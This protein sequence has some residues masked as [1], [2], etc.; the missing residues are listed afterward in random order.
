MQ[1]NVS[2]DLEAARLEALQSYEVLDSK[3]ERAFDDL[4]SLIADVCQ[5]P[6]ALVSLIDSGRQ[7]F[8]S[9]HGLDAIE[10]P[11]D[12][13]FCDHA[14]RKQ[15]VMVVGDAQQD[16]RFANNPLVTGAPNIRFY[17]GSPLVDTDGHALGTLCVIDREPRHLTSKQLETL[18]H[19]S[20]QVAHL[21]EMRRNHRKLAGCL[22]R[23]RSIADMIPMCGHC[24]AVRDESDEWQRV[25]QYFQ[26]VSGTQFTHG[27]CPVCMIEHYPVLNGIAQR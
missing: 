18:E 12:Q 7:W 20:R 27:V 25:E 10:T 1:P 6:I 9:R 5:T 26:E 8:K 16:E 4:T 3:S 15:G 11:R 17:A 19:L 13:A 2:E 23:I 24:N 14:I 21:L 22:E